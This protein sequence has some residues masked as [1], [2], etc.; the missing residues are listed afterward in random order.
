[1]TAIDKVTAAF[2]A[3][4]AKDVQVDD[5]I[6]SY[7]SHLISDTDDVVDE[8]SL[9]ESIGDLLTWYGVVKDATAARQ[10]CSKLVQQLQSVTLLP[11]PTTDIQQQQLAAYNNSWVT[12]SLGDQQ[13]K[14]MGPG[15][16]VMA[17][18][19]Y[20][21][22][23]YPAT[24]EKSTPDGSLVVTFDEYNT[25]QCVSLDDIKV[26]GDVLFEKITKM[27]TFSHKSFEQL[28]MEEMLIRDEVEEINNNFCASQDASGE[29]ANILGEDDEDKSTIT[30]TI[31]TLPQPIRIADFGEKKVMRNKDEEEL[32]KL[33][34]IVT[35]RDIKAQQKEKRR[36]DL[37]R[38]R[39]V[40][41]VE[42]D[43]KIREDALRKYLSESDSSK[44]KNV[45]LHINN[46]SLNSPDGSKELLENCTF[47]LNQGRVYGLIGSNG[48]GK[49]TL[50]KAIANYECPGVPSHLRIVHVEQEC[51]GDGYSAL[52]TILRGDIEREIL[53]REELR[54][55]ALLDQDGVVV[56]LPENS[57][58]LVDEGQQLKIATST[59]ETEN[60]E[61]RERFAQLFQLM[62]RTAPREVDPALQLQ[63]VYKR[64]ETIDA[65]TAEARAAAILKGLQFSPER[66]H[67]PTKKLSGGWRMR[68]SLAAA[69]FIQPDL[70][71]LD[72][73]T[74]HLDFPSVLWL[75]DYLNGYDK[76]VVVISHDRMF[77]NNVI[78]DVLH[79]HKRQL[80]TYK[81]DYSTFEKVRENQMK[82]Q[83][84]QFEAQ[85]E[86]M[87]HVQEFIDK[88]RFNANRAALVQS[89]IKQLQKMDVIEDVEEDAIFQMTFPSA[90]DSIGD[91]SV[92][93]VNNISFSYNGLKPYLLKNITCN[94]HGA[95]RVGILGANGIGKTTLLHCILGKL[96]ATEGSVYT[97]GSARISTFAQ[98][99]MD[100]LKPELTPLELLIEMFPKN[101]PQLIRRHLGRFGVNG[102]M[103]TQIISSLS[104]GQ[105]SRV[106]FS[107]LMWDKPHVVILDE[108]TNH[109][110]LETVDA[111]I[112][113]VGGFKGGVVVVSH[114]QHFLNAICQEY[115]VV[116]NAECKRFL[117]LA[118][119]KAACH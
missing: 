63:Q 5:S 106:A 119:A 59:D 35:K 26:P 1:M 69:L 22:L 58:C 90:D 101:H 55:K 56:D 78:T 75:E 112:G 64:M 41:R 108:P 84:R 72:E 39:E 34:T 50:L 8:Y 116:A 28:S 113:A 25:T 60:A 13:V 97:N 30:T 61:E 49:T 118:E 115:W 18:Y 7:V 89:R 42:R 3:L 103:Q 73:P 45:D 24:V 98:H 27:L 109:L 81:G 82:V 54:L 105:K 80:T 95:S 20:D 77:L 23:F 114:D 21:D 17:R 107:I 14:K 33:D 44:S 117:T 46:F 53:I 68:V 12:P 40:K 96:T 4:V 110:D 86:K 65:W 2:Q 43:Q 51:R 31:G 48:V 32:S 94:I 91:Q 15:C 47:S 38:Q 100:K 102:T 67:T 99:H 37:L 11:Q 57:K 104:G 36:L 16:L 66:M 76:T 92:I 9:F 87:S 85:Q 19:Y 52:Q 83:K 88:F 111:L 6:L 93:E 29:K 79:F 62:N 10:L 70:L 74:N 71:M